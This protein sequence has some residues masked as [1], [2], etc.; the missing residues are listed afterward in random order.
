MLS[1]CRVAPNAKSRLKVP[2]IARLTPSSGIRAL[3]AGPSSG[4]LRPCALGEA[5][6]KPLII[7]LLALQAIDLRAVLLHLEP[8]GALTLVPLTVLEYLLGAALGLT[9]LPRMVSARTGSILQLATKGGLPAGGVA[10]TLF[11]LLPQ[12]I[13]ER[14]AV[15]DAGAA[16]IGL[17][18]GYS[19]GGVLASVMIRSISR[20]ASL[21]TTS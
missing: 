5:S 11:T 1:P 6:I 20:M 16:R 15:G 21:M 10:L 13:M 9:L 18:A 4:N 12:E 19:R 14:G 17:G 3:K 2:S 7:V 8:H